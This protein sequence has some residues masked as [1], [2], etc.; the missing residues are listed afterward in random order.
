MTRWVRRAAAAV[1]AVAV[2]V[3]LALPVDGPLTPAAFLRIPVEAL[4]GTAL[5][6]VLPA[7]TRPVVAAALGAVLGL[8]TVLGL[9]HI[10]FH[11][12]LGRP[13]DP[14]VDAPLFADGMRFLSGTLGTPV[15]V[16]AAVVAG[17]LAIA[18]PVGLAA[19]VVRLARV[20]AHRRT[21]AARLVAVLVPVWIA[22]A[23]LGVQL[24]P[25]VPV[26]SASAATLAR[27]TAVGIPASLQAQREFAARLTADPLRDVPAAELVAA[28]RGKDVVVV[29][30]ESYG[31]SAVEDPEFAPHVG[32]LLDDGT[33]R[34]T[35]AGF[36]ARSAWLTS[37]VAGGSSWLAHATFL[38]GLPVG[39][40]GR[41]DALV[42]SERRTLSRVFAEAGWRTVAVQPGTTT[43]WPAAGFY[44]FTEVLDFGRLGYRG[45]DR[46]WASVPD[47]FTLSA[48]HRLTHDGPPVMAEIDLVSSHAPWRMIPPVVDWAELGD[49]Q[50]FDAL[51]APADPEAI[52]GQ[53]GAA[54]R[55]AYRGAIEYSLAS[56]VS[57]VEHLG[58][59]DLVLLV[60]GD[61]QPAPAVTGDGVGRDV[62]ISI[63]TRDRTV[64]DR[65][66]P[67]GWADGLRPSPAAPVW[68]MAD[69]RDRFL[70]A[71][72]G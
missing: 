1:A 51:A 24:V 31:R 54:V 29:F 70:A 15:A 16:V 6:L 8:L 55:A 14:V 34:L 27:D 37:P 12:V 5:L 22:L 10:G 61:H 60:L 33:A 21:G 17:L 56:L 42:A 53:G 18:L 45:P 39:D 30:V 36:G 2:L 40:Q 11:A 49:G 71:F 32:P 64:L 57:Y 7:R 69:F 35:A 59:D 46:G 28:L 65:I 19:A 3:A 66:A 9:L 72:R 52:W 41:Y 13:F 25:G 20:V 58:D 63:V 50:V 23:V 62:P 38:S 67:W 47:Q 44:G 4:A 26:A 48:F 68:P 43:E